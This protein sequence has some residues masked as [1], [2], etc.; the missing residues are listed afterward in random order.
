MGVNSYLNIGTNALGDPIGKTSERAV[1]DAAATPLGAATSFELDERNQVGNDVVAYLISLRAKGN[2]VF[3]SRYGDHASEIV[4]KH[5]RRLA[6]GDSFE[7]I[8][9]RG[10]SAGRPLLFMASSGAG[11]QVL[12][13]VQ[14]VRPMFNQAGWQGIGP[15][16][17]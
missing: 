10:S 14:E 6:V 16:D 11:A 1:V 15:N 3:V 7:A 4:D 8:Y 13:T 2:D 9:S 12:I 5:W 17:R